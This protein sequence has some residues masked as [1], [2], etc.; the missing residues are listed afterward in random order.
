MKNLSFLLLLFLLHFSAKAQTTDSLNATYQDTGITSVIIDSP[1]R[2]TNLSP[3]ITLHVDSTLSYPLQIN[4]NEADYYWYLK[5]S[6]VG[7]RINKDNGT[8][9]FKA[10]KSYFLSGRL[11]YDVNYKVTVGVQN[12]HVPSEKMDTSFSLVFY[13][14]EIIPSKVKP[15]ISN[16]VWVDEGETIAFKVLCETGSFPFEE[17]LTITSSPIK[18]YNGVQACGNV[19]KWAIPYDLVKDTDSGRV[20]AVILSFIGATRFK[21]KDTA[22]VKVMVRDALNY[23]MALEEY[24][25][26]V[27]KT[28]QYIL[29]LKL[30]FLQLDKKLKKTRTARTTFDLTSAITSLTGTVLSTSS[31][32]QAQKTG[33]ILPSI[34]LAMVPIKEATVPNRAVDQNQAALIRTS[35]KRLEYMVSDNPLIGEQDSNITQKTN[36]LTNELKQVQIQLIDVPVEFSND[37]TEAALDQYFNNPKVNKKYRLKSR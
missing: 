14:T 9:H 25:Q 27:K 10:E 35:I 11:K 30:T 18:E 19:F 26:T 16:V 13:S 31:S 32:D 28:E 2:I 15:A 34:G 3:Y 5:N 29:Q 6:P 23:P 22:Q 4:K 7:L 37:F 17:I 20:K 24:R 21:I 36:R 33:K 1:L 12:L 8:L